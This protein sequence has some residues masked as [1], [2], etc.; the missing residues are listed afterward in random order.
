[1][2]FSEIFDDK[3]TPVITAPQGASTGITFIMSYYSTF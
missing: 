1:V 3:S 2:I